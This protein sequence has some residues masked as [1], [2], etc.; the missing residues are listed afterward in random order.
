MGEKKRNKKMNKRTLLNILL[1]IT[2]FFILSGC[3]AEQITEE[4]PFG[5]TDPNQAQSWFT[6]GVESGQAIQAVGGAT[7]DAALMGFGATLSIVSGYLA[8]VILGKGKKNGA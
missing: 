7:G 8:T 2:L 3:A 4:N 6:A 1:L 5:I